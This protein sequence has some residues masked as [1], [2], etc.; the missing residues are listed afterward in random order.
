MLFYDYR[1]RDEFERVRRLATRVKEKFERGVEAS[2]LLE[3]RDILEHACERLLRALPTPVSAS[4]NIMRHIGLMKYYLERNKRERASSDFEE[5]AGSDLT[6]LEERF[7][8]WLAK[9]G[10]FDEDFAKRIGDLL[11]DQ[12]LGDALRAGFVMLT[13]RLRSA[14]ALPH[15]V[16]GRDLVNAIFGAKGI[17]A[18][19]MDQSERE[20]I[21][22]LLDGLYGVHRNRVAH[23][24]AAIQWYEAE[25]ALT[26]INWTLM[27]LQKNHDR[28]GRLVRGGAPK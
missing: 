20:A 21:R 16:D 22:N 3:D 24:D 10:H 13:D 23:A 19:H 18:Q 27:W 25:A 12:R 8:E 2:E 26:M 7:K 1:I 17:L 11:Y 4:S 9:H 14:F 15:D 28:L 6:L 5:V